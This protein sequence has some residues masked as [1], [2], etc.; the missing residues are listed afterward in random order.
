MIAEM[1]CNSLY[2][3]NCN[4]LHNI[5]LCVDA[6]CNGPLGFLGFSDNGSLTGSG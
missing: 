4:V 6:A 3:S 2:F 1:C 5:L